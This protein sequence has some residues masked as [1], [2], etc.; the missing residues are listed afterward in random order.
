MNCV[1]FVA[2]HIVNM[3]SARYLFI[4]ISTNTK[5]DMYVFRGDPQILTYWDT[6]TRLMLEK[7]SKHTKSYKRP[8]NLLKCYKSVT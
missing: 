2:L 4:Q 5:T 8:K 1:N 6:E 3:L 7:A